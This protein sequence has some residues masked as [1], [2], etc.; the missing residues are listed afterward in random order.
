MTL[1]VIILKKRILGYIQKNFFNS[2]FTG[3]N[4]GARLFIDSY[5]K[6]KQTIEYFKETFPNY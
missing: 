4:K 2:L 3:Q 5:L 6:E 1:K